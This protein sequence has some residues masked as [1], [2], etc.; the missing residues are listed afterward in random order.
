MREKSLIHL[1][2]DSD[3]RIQAHIS[4]LAKK[5]ML[6]AIFSENYSVM[7]GSAELNF[8]LSGP[9]IELGSGAASIKEVIPDVIT[10][11]VVKSG[12]HDKV[13]DGQNMDLEDNSIS[14]IFCQNVFHHFDDPEKFFCE[15]LRV[16]KP[17][18]GI[19]MIEPYHGL[20]AGFI[21]GKLIKDETFD[22]RQKLWK[23]DVKGPMYG[24]NQALSYIVFF[25]DKWKFEADFPQLKLCEIFILNNY[26][27]YLF[28]GGLNFKQILPTCFEN[29][30]RFVEFLLRPFIKIFGLHHVIVIKKCTL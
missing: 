24:A 26:L 21:Y 18:G 25:R 20:L 7:K 23:T 2:M 28:S 8:N 16:L 4:I 6:R 10:S 13:I 9:M 3:E 27:R 15:C 17:N 30:L 22:K 5:P 12:F 1:D 11:D 29:P 14:T 19:V